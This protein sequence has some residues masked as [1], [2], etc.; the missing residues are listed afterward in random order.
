MSRIN[1][2]W[3]NNAINADLKN[4]RCAPIFL[5]LWLALGVSGRASGVIASPCCELLLL[6]IVDV[7]EHSQ[8]ADT[9]SMANPN[10]P[11][12]LIQRYREELQVRHY[13]RRTVSSYEGWLRRFLCFHRMRHPREMGR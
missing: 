13:A 11:P 5:R 6:I 12:G 4:L 9:P 7:G 1:N 10:Q 2:Y 3:P 8:C